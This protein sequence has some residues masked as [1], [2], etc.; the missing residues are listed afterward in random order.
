M[1]IAELNEFSLQ[2]LVKS[3]VV[4]IVFGRLNP[5]PVLLDAK[6]F[7]GF[8]KVLAKLR[9]IVMTNSWHLS[10]QKKAKSQEKITGVNRTFTRVHPSK[11]KFAILVYSRENV[12]L[13][14][15]PVDDSDIKADDV[16]SPLFVPW[17]FVK[18]Q[19]SNSFLLLRSLSFS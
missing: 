4:R 9:T 15:I 17:Q 5:A 14:T 16:A 6:L 18:L 13:E 10:T 12:A 11:G 7:T 8:L 1:E 3:F 2:R 19:F